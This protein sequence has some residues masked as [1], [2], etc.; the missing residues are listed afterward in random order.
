MWAASQAYWLSAQVIEPVLVR[1][2]GQRRA[3]AA[4][5]QGW[6]VAHLEPQTNRHMGKGWVKPISVRLRGSAL[7][8]KLCARSQARFLS[9]P[10]VALLTQVIYDTHH[11]AVADLS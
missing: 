11:S 9:K 5:V 8:P 6:S 4:E 10:V 2:G 7:R 1:P 3:A